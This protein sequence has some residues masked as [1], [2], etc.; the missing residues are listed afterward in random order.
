VLTT[1]TCGYASHII[2]AGSGE[3]CGEPF[4]QRELDARL[5]DML[6]R[7]EHAPWQQ[8]GL[9]YGRDDSLC[10]MPS[11]AIDLLEQLATPNITP[12]EIE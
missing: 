12:R 3:V 5:L 10:Q 7:L 4:S 6:T 1:A 9:R 2:K 11:A 8:N